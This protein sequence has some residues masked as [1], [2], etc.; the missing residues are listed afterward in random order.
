MYRSWSP[1]SISTKVNTKHFRVMSL[2]RHIR[3]NGKKG[4]KWQ[5]LF[6]TVKF[7]ETSH[8]YRECGKSFLKRKDN[9]SKEFGIKEKTLS[10]SKNSWGCINPPVKQFLMTTLLPGGTLGSFFFRYNERKGWENNVPESYQEKV[11]HLKV[12]E[13]KLQGS[14]SNP[15]VR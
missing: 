11:E 13:I 12:T 14:C 5:N 10:F 6:L 1:L 2:W 4:G 8:F 7:L 3:Q 15:L 9:I